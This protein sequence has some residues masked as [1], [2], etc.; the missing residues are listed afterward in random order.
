VVIVFRVEDSTIAI[1]GAGSLGTRV[2]DALYQ[3]GHRNIIATRT[4]RERLEEI[5]QQ[6]RTETTANNVDATEK[7]D[8]VVMAVK[9]YRLEDV[10]QE[11]AYVT[12]EKLVISLAAAR[13]IAQIEAILNASRV[14]RVMTGIFVADEIAAYT[15]G[16]RC[17]TED[18][19]VIR[20]IFGDRAKEVKEDALA[21]RTW[22]ACDT[23]LIAKAIEY[24][25]AAL[26]ELQHDEARRMYGATLEGIA[27]QFQR[28]MTGHEIF[29]AVAGPGSFTGKLHESLQ[30]AGVYEKLM[31]CVKRTVEACKPKT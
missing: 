27:K 21:D 10:C 7:S 19:G 15:L 17:T 22:I 5:R 14:C 16:S 29:S 20:Y 28:G 26:P 18:A 9:P 30:D 11:I 31:D 4:N 23:G 12:R 6:F 8:V 3:R 24:Q 2:I 1:L 25:I 13:S